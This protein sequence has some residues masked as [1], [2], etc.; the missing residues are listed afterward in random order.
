MACYVYDEW[1]AVIGYE[2][3][4]GVRGECACDDASYVA[5]SVGV[6]ESAVEEAE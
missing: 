4:S 3:G 6:A 1:A 2:C 5:H